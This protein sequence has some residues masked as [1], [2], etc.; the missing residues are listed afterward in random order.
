MPKSTVYYLNFARH[1]SESL[2]TQLAKLLKISGLSEVVSKSDL[3][4]VK[5]H[6]GEKGNLAYLR[7]PLAGVVVEQIKALGAAPFITDSTTLYVGKRK[8]GVSLSSL[9]IR[10]GFAPPQLDAPFLPADGLRGDDVTE[11]PSPVEGGETVKMGAIVAGANSLVCLSHFK[12]HEQTSFGGAIKNLSMGCAAKAGKFYMHVDS[13]PIVREEGCTACGRCV[14]ECAWS[15]ITITGA[16]ARIDEDACAGCGHCL[17]V[18]PVHTIV[19]RWDRAVESLQERMAVYATALHKHLRGRAL[20]LNFITDV[21]PSCDCFP[22]HNHPLVPDIGIVAGRDPVAVDAASRDLVTA[23]PGLDDCPAGEDKFR[24]IYPD[25][26]G[27]IQLKVAESLGL[28]TTNYT[29]NEV[30]L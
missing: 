14:E 22:Y 17:V 30:T 23:A 26:D 11:L 6:I 15:A 8:D 29:I 13:K 16:T 19:F 1:R 4:A 27:N 2:L 20:Y 12:G 7:P 24:K 25:V 18:C 5:L 21:S 28:G 10:H 3:T 9:A